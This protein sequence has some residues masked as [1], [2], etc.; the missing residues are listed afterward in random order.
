MERAYCLGTVEEELF[1][2]DFDYQ[3][4]DIAEIETP[5]GSQTLIISGWWGS[6]SIRGQS[7]KL[8]KRWEHCLS[9]M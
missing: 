8:G 7:V 5:K 9:Y 3:P 6:M 2:M 4:Y 1:M